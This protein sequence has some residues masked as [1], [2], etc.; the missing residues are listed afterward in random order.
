MNGMVVI[1]LADLNT[2]FAATSPPGLP[3]LPPGPPA[4]GGGGTSP[5]LAAL[6]TTQSAANSCGKWWDYYDAIPRIRSAAQIHQTEVKSAT[7]SIGW[8]PDLLTPPE[9]LAAW[10]DNPDHTPPEPPAELGAALETLV[11]LGDDNL[12]AAIGNI[13][14]KRWVAGRSYLAAYLPAAACRTDT[15]AATGLALMDDD[16]ARALLTD[17]TLE[18]RILSDRE[19]R[20]RVHGTHRVWQIDGLAENDPSGQTGRWFAAGNIIVADL[21]RR[22]PARRNIP[23]TALRSLAGDCDALI[24]LLKTVR[25]VANSQSAAGVMLVPNTMVHQ[26]DAQPEPGKDGRKGGPMSATKLLADSLT[27]PV[28]DEQAIGA[29]LPVVLKGPWEQ[30]RSVRWLEMRRSFDAALVTMIELYDRRISVGLDQ[31]TEEVDG[32]ADS[33]H[34]SAAEARSRQLD[35]WSGQEASDIAALVTRALIRPLLA[36]AGVTDA[37]QWS[38]VVDTSSM[39][40]S[41]REW[42]VMELGKAGMM[43]PAAVLRELG[44]DPED[45][46]DSGAPSAP[47]NAGVSGGPTRAPEQEQQL[48]ALARAAEAM[49]GQ[50]L[51]TELEAI[52]GQSVTIPPGD[53]ARGATAAGIDLAGDHAASLE[54][55]TATVI[56][57]ATRI[58]TD[59]DGLP[60][61]MVSALA[62]QIAGEWRQNLLTIP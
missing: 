30:L 7:Y 44:F 52:T 49:L 10:D 39:D 19:I 6:S 16:R 24:A 47:T 54:A 5:E 58:L 11:T 27:A 46:V 33:N 31:Q 12:N 45:A 62:A 1:D 18:W 15:E 43:A 26:G 3:I 61:E 4:L 55:V 28:K 32:V 9:P 13:A 36:A 21:I 2:D 51:T 59:T 38:L 50:S 20:S 57:E 35:R 23:D 41:R 48:G 25:I 8:R 34:W 37:W 56:T 17:A 53:V 42:V 40:T 60:A 22:H 29:F 14:I